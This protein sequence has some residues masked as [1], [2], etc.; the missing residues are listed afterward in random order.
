MVISL[1]SS[2]GKLEKSGPNKVIDH[3]NL[4]TW[5]NLYDWPIK[6]SVFPF[7]GLTEKALLRASPLV[8]SMWLQTVKF[9]VKKS[10]CAGSAQEI[11]FSAPNA[12]SL[13]WLV[14]GATHLCTSK[15]ECN[16]LDLTA[17]QYF[18]LVDYNDWFRWFAIS[19]YYVY[20]VP[21]KLRHLILLSRV[22]YWA[23]V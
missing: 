1:A 17:A 14:Q 4:T 23:L 13:P 22:T 5:A 8:L 12:C 18:S 16:K 6:N 10:K 20:A 3:L 21:V 9:V 15:T 11:G 7:T 19:S 2:P